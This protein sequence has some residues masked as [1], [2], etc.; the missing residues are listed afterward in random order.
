MNMLKISE[1]FEIYPNESV[2]V[3]QF[4]NIMKDV[5]SNTALVDREEFVSELV[6][7]FYRANHMKSDTIRFKEFTSYLI[8]HEINANKKTSPSL[9]QYYESSIEDNTTHS[10][11]IEKIY[12]FE[13]VD[14][15]IMYEQ[16]MKVLRIYDGATMKLDDDIVCPG[17]ILAVECIPERESIVVSLADRVL[18]VYSLAQRS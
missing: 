17:T 9:M 8:E 12:Y 6:D 14:K 10:S 3:D 5:L 16:S 2:D 13:E 15:V 18:V 1:K 11:Y 4:V 7:L